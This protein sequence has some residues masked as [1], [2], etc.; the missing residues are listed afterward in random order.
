MAQCFSSY[1]MKSLKQTFQDDTTPSL[2]WFQ[3]KLS[4][5]YEQ[6]KRA[7]RELTRVALFSS[8]RMNFSDGQSVLPDWSL[9]L[10]VILHQGET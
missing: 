8:V 6:K 4:P 9:S 2:H 1:L 5:F 10:S 3:F 7:M